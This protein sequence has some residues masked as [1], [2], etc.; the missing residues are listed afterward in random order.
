MPVIIDK[1]KCTGCGA[2]NYEC[3]KYVLYLDYDDMKCHAGEGCND[4][5]ICV[6]RCHWQAITLVKDKKRKKK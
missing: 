6:E 2:C 4:C 3:P 1:L 5:G